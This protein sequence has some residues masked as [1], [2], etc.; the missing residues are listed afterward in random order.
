MDRLSNWLA[1][2]TV[3]QVLIAWGFESLPVHHGSI[4]YRISISVCRTEGTGSTPV[5]TATIALSI[6]GLNRRA[7]N[8]ENMVRL[9]VGL[10]FWRLCMKCEN[11]FCFN[12]AEK[13]YHSVILTKPSN[14]LSLALCR[15]CYM[16]AYHILRGHF[17]LTEKTMPQ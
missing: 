14:P 9:H 3:D 6:N 8:T 10:P 15:D 4:V 17:G 12:K 2:L 16:I 13:D 7:D 1:R 5:R 11:S